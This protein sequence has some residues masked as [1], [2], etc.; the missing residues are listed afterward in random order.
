M[1][2]DDGGP[3][4]QYSN[5]FNG[6]LTLTAP[7]G[8]HVRLWGNYY[9]M[10]TLWI[11][12]GDDSAGRISC[13][14]ISD[15]DIVSQSRSLTLLFR[16]S[17]PYPTDGF[18]F[19][20]LCEG[21]DSTVCHDSVG[22]IEISY[23]NDTAVWLHWTGRASRYWLAANGDTV[24]QGSTS[25]MLTGLTAGE[26][27]DVAVSVQADSL[28]PCCSTRKRIKA[29]CGRIS[30]EDLPYSYGF[31]NATGLGLGQWIDPCWT[32]STSF[33]AEL[34]PSGTT[35]HTGAIAMSLNSIHQLGQAVL[36]M[37]YYTQAVNETMLDFWVKNGSPSGIEVGV[38]S[39]P[40]DMA[41]F[42]PVATVGSH[43]A[44]YE[45]HF[46][47][48]ESYSGMGHYVAFRTSARV[49][50]QILLD[51]VR[52]SWQ[53]EC[54]Q[55]WDLHV[56]SQ[57]T[58]S[59]ALDWETFYRSNRIVQYEI[60]VTPSSGDTTIMR[61]TTS[62]PFIIEGLSP[63]SSYTV[64]VRAVCRNGT[65]GPWESLEVHTE[66]PCVG[67]SEA[68]G[69]P[70]CE[71]NTLVPVTSYKGNTICQSIYT[72]EQLYEM[73]VRPGPISK[74]SYTWTENNT[75][76]KQLSIYLTTTDLDSYILAGMYSFR[77]EPVTEGQT[78]VY[79]GTHP[80]YTQGQKTY[81]FIEP[82]YWDG[83]SN[84]VITTI[85]NQPTGTTHS[86]SNFKGHA[87]LTQTYSTLYA[88]RNLQAYE[89]GDL[90]TLRMSIS[91]IQPCVTLY[92]CASEMRCQAPVA[93]V[94]AVG[95]TEVTLEW[96][97][98]E[99]VRGWA[100]AYRKAEDSVWQTVET[101][102]SGT[103]YHFAN[104]TTSTK[105]YFRVTA[106]CDSGEAYTHVAAITQCKEDRL[107][108]NDLYAP[109]VT[110]Y[111]G[112]FDNP[113]MYIGAVNQGP[114]SV[115]SRHTVH[116]DV[117]EYDLRT[118]RQLRT[119]PE[120]Y[121]SSV[122]L[123]NWS[124]G[125]KAE[126][127]SYTLQIDTT[128]YD[129]LLL[130][131][132][133][134]LENPNHSDEQQPRFSFSITDLND[135]LISPCYSADFI[136]NIDLGWNMTATG[137]LWKDW[138][139]LGIDLTPLQGQTI[140]V[141]LT[142]Y[143]CSAGGHFGYAYFVLDLDNKRISSSSCNSGEN[144]FNAPAGFAYRWY[145]ATD[146]T[147]T[148]S[149]ADTVHVVQPGTYYCD[150]SFVGAPNDAAHADCHFTLSAVA[151]ER[152]PYAR[153]DM[154]NMDTNRCLHVSMKMTN[155][156][157][158]TSDSAH[159]DSI[160]NG[161]ESYL[162]DFGDGSSSTERNPVHVYLPGT[163]RVKLYAMLA[164][165]SCA[166][167]AV[168]E[169]TYVNR[170]V[171]YDTVNYSMCEG[172]TLRT[173]DTMLTRAG[174]YHLDTIIAGDSVLSRTLRLT[175]RHESQHLTAM[176]VCDSF[177][178]PQTSQTYTATGL[179]TDTL[180]NQ[181]GCDSL[182]QLNLTVDTS[183]DIHFYDTIYMGDT[184]LFEGTECDTPGVYVHPGQTRLG[185]DSVRTL[186]LEWK[187]LVA[188]SLWATI[189]EGEEFEFIDT[190]LRTS[191]IYY[192]TIH[193][194]SLSVADTQRK[195]TLTVKP[196]PQIA[197]DSQYTCQ[198][199]PH[200]RLAAHPSLPYCHWWSNPSDPTL[201][202]QAGDSVITVNPSEATTYY[203]M[204]EYAEEPRCTVKDSI[205]LHT[206]EALT[207]WIEVNPARLVGEQRTLTARSQTH[208]HADRY[209]W[210]LWYDQ[211]PPPLYDTLPD[212]RVEVPET[213]D[214]LR[215]QLLAS[216]ELCHDTDWVTIP[217][218][219][220]EIFFPNIFTPN[221]QEN[222]R[223]RAYYTNI[224]D[225]EIWI[226]DRRGDLVYHSTDI[227][228]GWDGT[229]EDRPCVQA[230]YVYTCTYK[231]TI[232]PGGVMKKTGTVVLVR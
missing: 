201:A 23:I 133:A 56:L 72:A 208:G 188:D 120:G 152:Y 45:H 182:V 30:R 111:T 110:C 100:I 43:S 10:D 212:I 49:L 107:I 83:N 71:S 166:D 143:D 154:E 130:K 17:T 196:L 101:N 142:T 35:P 148:L 172:D 67:M 175:V 232:T 116:Y 11:W 91:V 181:V 147:C 95:R 58:T 48:F 134:V 42:E 46:V 202:G 14:W 89:I 69:S 52:L 131:Y 230:A 40:C 200:Y 141:N 144:T 90:D 179:Y 3:D 29:T 189:C 22:D 74:I 127:I 169:F 217:I 214:S 53:L 99:G 68:S 146:T 220:S 78:L 132:A 210:Y 121:C 151:G 186:H 96:S 84:L 66:P 60:T 59:I 158:I 37:P 113:K 20:Y 224:T 128:D 149:R 15:V 192:R 159:C 76:D 125:A 55:I 75:F 171:R 62:H 219:K 119:V 194:E 205:E 5:S 8:M 185:C 18:A 222:N 81:T 123:G 38:M 136:S 183:Y 93:T 9:I 77:Y 191:G 153:F 102:Y 7:E 187:A 145:S 216:N 211:T 34:Y 106:L 13:I 173:F 51:D 65:Y 137:L 221:R 155:H 226:Y 203:V 184:L 47:S 213:A 16:A 168:Q 114:E 104:L 41:T 54:P 26:T 103:Q 4:H 174:V 31:E 115:D 126:S 167:T 109:N 64:T 209:E 94:K 193:M 164:G 229:H 140:K 92:S 215:I 85:M 170:C 199:D 25:Y 162:W 177:Y 105:Y 79:S 87:A 223:F 165:G 50:Q 2:Y 207:A 108:Y 118:N 88:S 176:T 124:G 12:D 150:L 157:I 70:L 98:D 163:Y 206:L 73:G 39:N 28:A 160:A 218:T 231:D 33:F 112:V 180:T 63:D 156:S 57:N 228:E 82:F 139:T 198:G 19:G 6:R 225:F 161:C 204:T 32:G 178:W 138:T 195:V 135:S 129:L 122:R 1:V 24:L 117:S 21:E 44:E 97:Q 36:A 197:I 80:L 86:N 61:T 227:N 190:V 27:Y